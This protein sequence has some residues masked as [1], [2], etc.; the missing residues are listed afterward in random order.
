M[1]LHD[2]GAGFSVGPA[3]GYVGCSLAAIH[4]G[5]AW[6]AA[7]CTNKSAENAEQ[8]RDCSGTCGYAA[9]VQ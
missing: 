3:K 6:I 8:D 7:A 4:T 9:D 1:R 5:T 2:D